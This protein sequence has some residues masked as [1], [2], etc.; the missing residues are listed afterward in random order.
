[1]PTLLRKHFPELNLSETSLAKWWALQLA[2]KGGQNLLTDILTI[3]QTEAALG[4]A[5]RLN[6]RSEEGIVQQ[7][8]LTAWPEIARLKEPERAAAVRL[9]QD[10]LVRLSYRCFPSYR[11]LI[12]EYQQ[13]LTAIAKDKTKDVATRLTALQENRT[14]MLA[15]AARARDYMDWFEI[16][17][18][19][20]T[21]EVFDDYMR[22]KDRLKANPTQRKDGPSLYLDKMDKIFQ[23]DEPKGPSMLPP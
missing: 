5:L 2:N 17:R 22:L 16:T 15:K 8:E 9:A 6:F 7:K 1:M 20:K 14:V 10:A 12:A 18:A 11:P 23:R 19:R 3:N 21:S 13:L 4:E